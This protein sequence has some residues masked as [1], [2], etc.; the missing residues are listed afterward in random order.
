MLWRTTEEYQA[1]ERHA[2]VEH[3]LWQ[4]GAAVQATAD[5]SCDESSELDGLTPAG[6]INVDAQD[7]GKDA[8]WALIEG[9]T[10]VSDLCSS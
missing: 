9:G 6:R 4:P 1:E 3:C 7:V 10:H 2:C 8:Q 5:E